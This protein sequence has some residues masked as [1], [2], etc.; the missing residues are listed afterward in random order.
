MVTFVRTVTVAFGGAWPVRFAPGTTPKT[1]ADETGNYSVRVANPG[2]YTIS[3]GNETSEIIVSAAAVRNG[4][5][6]DE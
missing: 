1:A 3:A 5:R 4:T 6:L 2:T